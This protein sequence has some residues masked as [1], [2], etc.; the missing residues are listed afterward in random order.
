[1]EGKGFGKGSSMLC[2]FPFLLKLGPLAVLC[3]SHCHL[4]SLVT[5]IE[6]GPIRPAYGPH[7][8]KMCAGPKQ[9]RCFWTPGFETRGGEGER[10]TGSRRVSS[11]ALAFSKSF[12][13]AHA[14]T[15]KE[16]RRVQEK[17]FGGLVGH[18]GLGLKGVMRGIYV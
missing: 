11:R 12:L 2:V 17:S 15:T 9:N 8:P 13:E 14:H 7:H 3:V 18:L 6:A 1:M 16:E 5:F 10:G 4:H